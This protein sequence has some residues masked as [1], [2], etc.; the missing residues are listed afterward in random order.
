MSCN[1]CRVPSARQTNDQKIRMP[2]KRSKNTLYCMDCGEPLSRELAAEIKALKREL[3]MPNMLVLCDR[4]RPKFR[5][6]LR[7]TW[8]GIK[9][10]FE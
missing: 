7:R 2:M 6:R 9:Y 1:H 4:C 10:L 5:N 8:N 3:E